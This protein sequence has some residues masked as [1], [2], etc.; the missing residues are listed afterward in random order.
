M[1]G[2]SDSDKL[3]DILLEDLHLAFKS[4]EI[5]LIFAVE[6]LNDR[7]HARCGS[8]VVT[9]AHFVPNRHS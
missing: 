1:S 2:F 4:L 8:E 6:L 7:M 5:L 9:S 3:F